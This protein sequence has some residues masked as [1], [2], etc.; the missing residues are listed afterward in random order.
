[1]LRFSKIFLIAVFCLVLAVG[2]V[3]EMLSHSAHRAVGNSPADLQAKTVEIPTA[4]GPVSG[5]LVRGKIGQGAI[6]LLHGVRSDRRQMIGRARFLNRLGYSVLLIDLPAHGESAGTR[7]TYGFHEAEG[8]KAALGY[9]SREF[10]SEKIGVIG[11]SLGA[12]SL[13][14]SNP[15][16]VLDAVVLESMFPSIE[17]AINDRLNLHLGV[18][19]ELLA[20]LLLWQLPEWLDVSAEQ[21]QP[22]AAI[23]SLRMPVLIASGAM[24]RHTTLAETKRIFESANNPKELWIVEG[25]AHVDLHAFEPDVYQ[26]RISSFL[27][28]Y[29]RHAG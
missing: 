3:G 19:G 16:T 24:D 4:N 10:P 20:P 23:A 12:A 28:K 5:W 6:L 9:I 8:V 15:T 27:A 22:I 1:M 11:V 7:I 14:L 25:A 2:S 17:E 18:M 21:L 29:L 26:K 13:V